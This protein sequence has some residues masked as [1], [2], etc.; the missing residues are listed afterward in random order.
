MKLKPFASPP[1]NESSASTSG[2]HIE[3]IFTTI[4]NYQVRNIATL[5]LSLSANACIYLE[6]GMTKNQASGTKRSPAELGVLDS[7]FSAIC[8]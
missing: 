5:M 4:G 1:S 2:G 7:L 3:Q 6:C 8:Y